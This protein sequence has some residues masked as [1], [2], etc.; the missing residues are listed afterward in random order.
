MACVTSLF[1]LI[2]NFSPVPLP[3]LSTTSVCLSIAFF[4]SFENFDF[5]VYIV[6]RFICDLM[7]HFGNWFC[8]CRAIDQT[9]IE[10][11]EK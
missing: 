8:I 6:L 11:K 10:K 4:G 2:K 5:Y 1:H 3:F 9:K 7:D